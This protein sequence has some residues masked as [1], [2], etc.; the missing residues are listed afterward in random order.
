[1]EKRTSIF[2]GV[3]VMIIAMLACSMPLTPVTPTT[4]P[5]IDAE[6]DGL[7]LTATSASNIPTTT[8][9]PAAV[10]TGNNPAPSTPSATTNPLA[11]NW[12]E[13]VAD[14]N[15]PDNTVVPSGTNFI[16]TWRLK[17][18]GS[19]TWTSGYKLLFVSGDGMSGSGSVQLTNGTVAP[20]STVDTNISLIAPVSNGTYQGNYKLQA[21]DGSVFGIGTN[22]NN[23]FY[24]KIKVETLQNNPQNEQ[25]VEPTIPPLTR[26]LQLKN[27]MMSGNDVKL[28][29][30]RLLD[31]GYNAVGVADGKFGPKTDNAVRS[32]QTDNSLVVDGIVGQ[33]TWKALWK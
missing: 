13:F 29:Q 22:A 23:V 15:Y 33:Q 1:M 8:L 7:G 20:G 2:I 27:P 19:C 14:V 10:S 26:L 3:S 9:T 18:I 25:A 4:T 16:K 28:L 30:N 32:F 12:A 11:C 21:A 6:N 31:L 5:T 17:N 24:V